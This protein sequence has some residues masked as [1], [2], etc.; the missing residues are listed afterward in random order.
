MKR[1][2]SQGGSARQDSV[3]AVY[4]IQ[5]VCQRELRA[6]QCRLT[7]RLRGTPEWTGQPIIDAGSE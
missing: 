4:Q 6:A 2:R 1:G 3:I 5:A 7:A